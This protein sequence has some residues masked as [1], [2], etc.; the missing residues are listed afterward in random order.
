M[1]RE[2]LNNLLEYFLV[3]FCPHHYEH[4][5]IERVNSSGSLIEYS[6]FD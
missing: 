6:D 2:L 4:R 5:S 1:I 3:K